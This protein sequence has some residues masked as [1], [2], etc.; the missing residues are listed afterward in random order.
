MVGVG[1]AALVET[2]RP[3]LLGPRRVAQAAGV[4]LLGTLARP[5]SGATPDAA[6]V[7]EVGRR[8]RLAASA[9][10][11]E[12]VELVATPPVD[13]RHLSACLEAPD[14]TPTAAHVHDGNGQTTT[15]PGEP[16]ADDAAHEAVDG[17]V[18]TQPAA[19]RR[20][21]RSL[22]ATR[23]AVKARDRTTPVMPDVRV[24]GGIEGAA[25]PAGVGLVIVAP[26]RTRRDALQ[27]LD[28]VRA[29]TRSRIIGVVTYDRERVMSRLGRV[30]PS[31]RGAS[32][33][34]RRSERSQDGGT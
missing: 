32:K 7:Q 12:A 9:A 26:S 10:N 6:D 31:L 3:T 5:P 15:A 16:P 19:R 4:A 30:M 25:S 14:P 34:W 18:P 13:L 29:L 27:V 17:D 1:L 21:R 23:V 28:D 24:F 22:S 8:V 11:L 2:V 20:P 33:R